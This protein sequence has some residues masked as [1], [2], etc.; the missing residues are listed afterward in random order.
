MRKNSTLS[1]RNILLKKQTHNDH[2]N[3]M[4]KNHDVYGPNPNTIRFILSYAKSTRRIKIKSGNNFII[5][6]N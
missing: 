6:L 5:S 3:F 4:N 1:L 2:E